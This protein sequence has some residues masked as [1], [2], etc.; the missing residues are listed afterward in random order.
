MPV[1]DD[2]ADQLRHINALGELALDV[3]AMADVDARHVGRGRRVDPG[4]HQEA[5]LDQVGNLRALDQ[6]F[7]D[8][9]ETAP[10]GDPGVPA[11]PGLPD[12]FAANVPRRLP[13]GA[14]TGPVGATG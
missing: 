14:V 2:V 12:G 9:A 10:V 1:G 11:A 3:V 6:R 7:E 13:P 5:Q 4:R 8:A